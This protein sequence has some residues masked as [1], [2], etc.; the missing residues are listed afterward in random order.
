MFKGNGTSPSAARL[1]RGTA[2]TDHQQPCW[3]CRLSPPRDP[4]AENS[5]FCRR[6]N[7]AIISFWGQ[8][9]NDMLWK[10]GGYLDLI[11]GS[12]SVL[13]TTENASMSVPLWT[14]LR[15]P[16]SQR[17]SA[18]SP[19]CKPA[20]GFYKAIL[21]ALIASGALHAVQTGAL[22]LPSL[23]GHVP[24]SETPEIVES[25]HFH[26][27]SPAPPGTAPSAAGPGTGPRGLIRATG[28]NLGFYPC[29]CVCD[30]PAELSFVAIS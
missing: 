15:G 10:K 22:E 20:P 9:E 25:T 12:S 26:P 17:I 28:G 11:P 13:Q 14:C 29:P 8:K 21:N 30:R 6:I 4:A 3:V 5:H 27:S 19:S 2:L 16:C 23:P 1:R 24:I 18:S 7:T